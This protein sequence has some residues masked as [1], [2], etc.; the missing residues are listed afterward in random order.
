MVSLFLFYFIRKCA[1]FQGDVSEWC[2]NF[3]RAARKKARL[4]KR[5]SGQP[6]GAKKWTSSAAN[7]ASTPRVN[8]LWISGQNSGSK[9]DS[10]KAA[11][12]AGRFRPSTNAVPG[13]GQ[14]RHLLRKRRKYFK[15]VLHQRR[16]RGT[17]AG[18]ALL[19]SLRFVNAL[20]ADLR[21]L[22]GAFVMLSQFPSR[23]RPESSP[24]S[25]NHGRRRGSLCQAYQ[26]SCR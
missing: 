4:E 14:G 6:A 2:I 1:H 3:S 5:A 21:Q 13:S 23:S 24:R 12:R 20:S 10:K 16:E 19:A 25:E 9:A 7:N 11:G 15:Y 8:T 18:F 26:R 22:R 17:F